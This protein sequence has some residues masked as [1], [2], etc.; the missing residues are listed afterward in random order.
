MN[1]S[2]LIE[3]LVACSTD[4]AA[5]N[6]YEVAYHALMA[7]L[8]A[9]EAADD[10]SALRDITE[11]AQRQERAIESVS[12]PHRLARVSAQARGT[13]PLYSSLALHI[14]AVRARIEVDQHRH[15]LGEG[16]QADGK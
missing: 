11:I 8:H 10:L 5:A 13:V 2:N 6:L 4:A 15:E 7:A 12:P 1:S 9:A 14:E 16:S 3:R